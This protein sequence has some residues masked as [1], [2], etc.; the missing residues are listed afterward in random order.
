M[1]RCAKNK[2]VQLIV[3]RNWKVNNFA[4]KYWRLNRK[5]HI[6]DHGP[7]QNPEQ[8]CEQPTTDVSVW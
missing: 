1:E 8:I 3:L 2:D 7:V 4:D 6:T 5:R